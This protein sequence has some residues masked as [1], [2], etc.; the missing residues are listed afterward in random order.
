MN[1][2]FDAYE[3]VG[4]IAPGS[5][6]IFAAAFLFPDVK[7]LLTGAD[8]SVGGLGLF[9]IMSYVAGQLLQAVGNLVEY[10]A[11]LPLGG[12]PTQWVL[13]GHDRLL[14]PQQHEKLFRLVRHHYPDFDRTSKDAAKS[15]VALTREIYARVRKADQSRRIDAFNRTYGL[16]RGIASGFLIAT[17]MVLVREPGNLEAIGLLLLGAALSIYRMCHFGK[18]YGRELLVSFITCE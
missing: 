18:L 11:W 1:E 5:V 8:V 15:W 10:L 6:A 2:K 9:V 17:V 12:M 16:M 13:K 4:V 3:Y 14:A 7:Q